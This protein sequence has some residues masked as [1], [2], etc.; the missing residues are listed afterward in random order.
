MFI[1]GEGLAISSHNSRRITLTNRRSRSK[2][3]DRDRHSSRSDRR[4]RARSRDRH[5]RRDKSRDRD[6]CT[7][8]PPSLPLPHV[9]LASFFWLLYLSLRGILV[10]NIHAQIEIDPHHQICTSSYRNWS[11][12]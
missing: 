6:R 7:R 2:D 4:D 11:A 5:S 12:N 1:C 10:T 9:I 8:L 3:R